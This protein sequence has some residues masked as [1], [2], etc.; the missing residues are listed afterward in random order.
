MS[1]TEAQQN[2]KYTMTISR[3]TV[4]KLGVKLY[5]RVSAVLAELV[6][7]SYDADATEVTIRAP[8]GQY[9]ATRQ[10]DKVVDKGFILEVKDNGIGMS[11]DEVNDFYLRVGAERRNDPRRGGESIKYHRK[12][13]GRKGVGKLA[14]FGICQRIEVISSGGDKVSSVDASGNQVEGYLT[15]HLVLDQS[16]I[17]TESD[18]E[19]HPEVGELDGTISPS[20]GT[21]LKLSI[22]A[23]RQVPDIDTLNRELAQRFGIRAINWT[24]KLEDYTKSEDHPDF[25]RE[26]GEFDVPTMPETIIRFGPELDL[27]G[28]PKEPPS[29]RAFSSEGHIRTDVE[30]GFTYNSVFYPLIGWIAYAQKNYKDDLV[31]GIRIYCRGKI[32]AQTS[33]FNLKSGFTG[34]YDVRSYVVGELHADWLDEKDDL[35]QTDRRDILWSHELGQEFERWGQNV[36]KLVGKAAR[37]PMKKKVWDVFKEASQIERKAQEAFPLPDQQPIRERAIE[38]AKMIGKTMREGEAQDPEAAAEIVK[39]SLTLAPHVTL[40][41]KLRE[42][43]ETQDSPLAV[44]TDILRTARIAE[45]SSFGRI[46]DD[47]IRVI[48]RVEELKDDTSTVEA[49]FQELISQAPWLIDPQWSPISANQSF[50]TLRSEF[51]KYY[52]QQTGEDI[53]LGDFS[54]PNKRPDFVLSN[55]DGII[56]IIEIKRPFH[57]FGNEEMQR[58]DRYVEQMTNFF[59]EPVHEGF[60]KIFRGF[61]VTLVCDEEA[62]TGVYKR[63]YDGLIANERLSHI[64]WLTFLARTRKMHEAFLQEAERQKSLASREEAKGGKRAA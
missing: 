1:Q 2:S 42:A 61:H 7:N 50:S 19:Y 9:L 22:F 4:D 54:D 8:M 24:I 26:V 62:L 39:L 33:I 44:I 58:L 12:V 31:A 25:R 63:A 52:K 55:Q 59:D 14:P 53:N 49:V 40:N 20:T 10:A 37:N 46:A 36:V 57:K 27:S 17:M 28:Q 5:D 18:E 11:P 16:C 56:Q 41:E 32:T 48:S 45:L 38:F 34:E 13:M 60:T 43:A 30:A 15:A 64:S 6:A 3:L 47:R 51:Q 29:Y 23:N 21:T 35:I